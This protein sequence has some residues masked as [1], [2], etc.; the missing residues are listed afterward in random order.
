MKTKLLGRLGVWLCN[1][2]YPRPVTNSE[3]AASQQYVSLVIKVLRGQCDDYGRD[4][5]VDDVPIIAKRRDY[6]KIYGSAE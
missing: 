1:N 6:A 4:R 3:G 2:Y 5:G